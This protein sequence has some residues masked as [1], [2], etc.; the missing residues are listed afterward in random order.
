MQTGRRA[1]GAMVSYRIRYSAREKKY[2]ICGFENSLVCF[3]HGSEEVEMTAER[4]RDEVARR[5]CHRGKAR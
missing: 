1:L 3:L 5:F 4:R 2:L